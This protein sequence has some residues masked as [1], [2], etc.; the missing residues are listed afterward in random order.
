M[1]G[2]TVC[3]PITNGEISNKQATN[4]P[5]C[6]ELSLELHKAQQELL[7]YEKV[8][9]VLREELTNMDQR[10]RPAGNPGNPGN[11]PRN[12]QCTKPMQRDRWRQVPFTTRKV[13]STRKFSS[14]T[15]IPFQNKFDPLTNLKEDSVPTLP[16][17]L[18]GSR[19]TKT[20]NHSVVKHN[21]LIVG[22]SHARNI[23]SKLQ[24]NLGKDY[25]VSGIVK[26]G[27]PM[28]D[29]LTTVDQLRV[30]TKREDV[31]VVW[32]GSNNINRNN[33]RKAISDVFNLVKNNLEHNIILMNAPHRHDLIPN[34]CVNKEVIK[35]NKLVRKIAKQNS[36][37]QF[38]EFNLDRSHFT[39]HGMHMNL[40]GKEQVSLH[41]AKLI[42]Q[43]FDSPQPH[44]IPIPWEQT[45]LDPPNSESHTEDTEGNI[46]Q[47]RRKCPKQK[48]PDFLWL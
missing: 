6:E 47:H 16:E 36:N 38:L 5:L 10:T 42:D 17:R 20:E 8:I 33:M 29:I 45:S 21:V 13:K 39:N 34:S 27:A 23:A 14:P 48:H 1:S 44:P 43:M 30:T 9:Q 7:S 32:G 3:V 28:E 46:N 25:S 37:T 24:L 35:Y 2:Y 18:P 12:D 19:P 41:L 40:K 15:T 22:D 11:L 4:C 31:L 26:P